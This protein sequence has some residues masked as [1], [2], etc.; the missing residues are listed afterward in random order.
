MLSP[1]SLRLTTLFRSCQWPAFA[2]VFESLAL[3]LGRQAGDC[4]RFPE[5]FKEP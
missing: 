4:R 1:K 2:V 3:R 5:D